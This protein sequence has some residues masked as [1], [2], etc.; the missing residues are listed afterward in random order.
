[1]YSERIDFLNRNAI[2]TALVLIAAADE[3]KQFVSV[4]KIH[5]AT[6]FRK[7]ANAV[8]TSRMPSTYEKAFCL[9]DNP[10]GPKRPLAG[11]SVPLLRSIY[12]SPLKLDADDDDNGLYK[13]YVPD[14]GPFDDL[15]TRYLTKLEAENY[16]AGGPARESSVGIN[17]FI[18]FLH[19]PIG[20]GKTTLMNLMIRSLKRCKPANV[21]WVPFHAQFNLI[22]N[23]TQQ[24][25]ELDKVRE[26]IKQR[27]LD[28]DAC[29]YLVLDNLMNGAVENAFNLYDDFQRQFRLFAFVTTSDSE[30][31][32][33]RWDA[34]GP[35]PI[36]AYETAELSPENAV[37]FVRSR[38]KVFRDE[39]TK[40]TLGARDLFPFNE[41]NIEQ[42][43]I[44]K[45]IAFDEGR[46][47]ITIRQ[48]S[49]A[50]STIL[51]RVVMRTNDL[52]GDVPPTAAQL[53]DAELDLIKE[54]NESIE[55]V[56]A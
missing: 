7:V 55:A 28:G 43:V 32:Q 17:S 36:E 50:L 53:A 15:H 38:V 10:F 12:I 37:A 41:Q 35:L 20:T 51:E 30:L 9:T 40:A 2:I 23:E 44:A 46:K 16:W 18:S 47:I 14:A 3:E 31:R 11:V 24:N 19:G 13:L 56:A 45:G 22:P 39:R 33:K 54:A 34:W 48:F 27:K 6:T 1:M 29:S 8:L 52:F 25:R 21:E 26:T 42:A 4:T 49:Q 5:L